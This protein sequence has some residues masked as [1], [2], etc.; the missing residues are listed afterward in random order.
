MSQQQESELDELG[1]PPRSISFV[2]SETGVD[3]SQWA[4]SNIPHRLPIDTPQHPSSQS[5]LSEQGMMRGQA[6]TM[7]RDKK[8][9]KTVAAPVERVFDS[10]SF[11][12]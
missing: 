7:H 10:L 6:A 5:K 3:A 2:A 11:R 1:S 12:H 8:K 9:E 4:S